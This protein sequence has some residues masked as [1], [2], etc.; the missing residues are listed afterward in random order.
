MPISRVIG[1]VAGALLFIL[2]NARGASPE[3]PFELRVSNQSSKPVDFYVDRRLKCKIPVGYGCRVKIERGVHTVHM[4]R[5]DNQ[6]YNDTF[7]L[8]EMREG[9]EYDAAGY[10][11]KDDSV[12]YLLVAP[13]H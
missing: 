10:L 7:M 1:A 9:K 12:H 13:H 4:V 6:A 11:V 2:L 8:P 3:D 5:S